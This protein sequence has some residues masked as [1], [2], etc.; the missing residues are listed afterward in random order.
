MIILLFNLVRYMIDG[1]G[2]HQASEEAHIH[3]DIKIQAF[4]SIEMF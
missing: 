4:T 3:L 2:L 1:S